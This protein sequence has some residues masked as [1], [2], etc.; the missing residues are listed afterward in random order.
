MFE[1]NEKNFNRTKNSDYKM[2]LSIFNTGVQLLHLHAY[3]N[4]YMHTCR[5][6]K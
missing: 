4:M 1:S 2:P 3:I 6:Y 5:K